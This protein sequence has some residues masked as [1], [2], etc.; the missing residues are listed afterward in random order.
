MRLFIRNGHFM[1]WCVVGGLSSFLG[2]SAA[3]QNSALVIEAGTTMTI[4]GNA[5]VFNNLDLY[6]NGS[7]LV[8]SGT[9]WV[10][11][12]NNGSL[13]GAG[14][15]AVHTPPLNNRASPV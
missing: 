12:S 3:A 8:P 14:G 10:T 1:S 6:C 5:M 9:V 11:G 2:G 7:L 15:P 13:N 4:A